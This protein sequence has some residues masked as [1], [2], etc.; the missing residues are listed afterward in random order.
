MA[1]LELPV[2]SDFPAYQFKVTLD[3]VVFQLSFNFNQ[4][5]SR[6]TM[7]IADDLGTE[8]VNGIALMSGYPISAQYVE[9][10]M[11][12]GLFALIDSTVPDGVGR[13]ADADD[14]GNDIK[15]LYEEAG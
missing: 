6:W 15:L 13:S 1:V 12:A 8:I 4:R 10:A 3:G 9:D 5:L 14:L 2:R 7:D 11:P